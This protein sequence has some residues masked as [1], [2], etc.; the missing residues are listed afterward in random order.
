MIFELFFKIAHGFL[1]F[2]I[3]SFVQGQENIVFAFDVL[4]E[5]IYI[6]GW[7]LIWEAFSLFF[8][9]TYALR[10]RKNMYLRFLHSPIRFVYKEE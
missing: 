6:G 3:A 4:L 9:K 10:K 7:V 2:F 8:F 1:L 5:G